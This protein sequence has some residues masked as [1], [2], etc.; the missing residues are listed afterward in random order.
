MMS[1]DE[2]NG[3]GYVRLYLSPRDMKSKKPFDKATPPA[4]LT[5]SGGVMHTQVIGEFPREG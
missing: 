5:L 1:E 3:R 2:S 4:D